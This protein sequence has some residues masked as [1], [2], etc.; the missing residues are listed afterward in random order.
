VRFPYTSFSSGP[1]AAFPFRQDNQRPL[2]ILVIQHGSKAVRTLAIVDSGADSCIF[3]ASLARQLGISLPNPRP[4]V[5]SG[6]VSA[7]QTAYFEPLKARV[8]DPISKSFVFDFDLY[9]GFCETLEHVGLG[10]LGQEGF[11]SRFVVSFD[12]QQ[13]SFDINSH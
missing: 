6:T 3:P 10:L 8:W 7:P 9:A 11:F 12:R 4:S 2:L 13:S 5:F 1:D